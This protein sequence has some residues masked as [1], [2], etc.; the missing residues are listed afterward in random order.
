MR[1]KEK[2]IYDISVGKPVYYIASIW[3]DLAIKSTKEVRC[4]IV[5]YVD[6][7]FVECNGL[8]LDKEKCFSTREQ[9][10]KYLKKILQEQ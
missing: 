5:D 4:R 10:E 3:N 7:V 1:N 2:E 6:K 8:I 9:A